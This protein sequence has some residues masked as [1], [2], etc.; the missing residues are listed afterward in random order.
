MTSPANPSSTSPKRLLFGTAGVPHSADGDSTVKGIERVAALGLDCLEIEAV[1]GVHMGEDT[2]RQVR[3]RAE[4]RGIRL[5]LHAPYYINLLSPEEGKRLASQKYI[6]TSVRVAGLCGA[7]SVVFHAGYYRQLGPQEAYG[8]VK[9]AVAEILSV[10]KSERNTVTLRIETMG[11]PKQFG[12]LEEVLFLCRDLEGL[13]P[14]LDFSHIHAREGRVNS[15]PEFDR[16]LRKLGR[17]L[18]PAALKDVHFHIAGVDYGRI[19]EI[20]HL[21]LKE[22]DFQYDE[23]IEALKENNVSGTVICESPNL[24]AD[25]MMLKKL[26]G[27]KQ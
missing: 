7:R 19:G 1:R 13:A 6:I 11:R 12:T 8:L 15:F 21:D 14:C 24:E 16:I 2:A 9:K 4:A 20:K 22:S 25:A 17:K 10:L 23:W 5:S 26:Y 3:E 27:S 18:G